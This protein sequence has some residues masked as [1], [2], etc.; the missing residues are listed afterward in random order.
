MNMTVT[1]L[2]KLEN[3]IKKEMEEPDICIWQNECSVD[4]VT[5]YKYVHRDIIRKL[6]EISGKYNYDLTGVEARK[7]K[8][9]FTI[10]KK[11]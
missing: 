10:I 2:K 6:N 11:A 4:I 9:L 8:L 3:E 1:D 5:P 7:D